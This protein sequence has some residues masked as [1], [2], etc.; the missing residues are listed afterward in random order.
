ML[1]RSILSPVTKTHVERR[2]L[3]THPVHLF[4]IIENV[5]DYAFFLPLCSYSKIL[6]RHD[7]TSF[8]ARLTVGL[9]PFFEETYVSR[10]KTDPT[11][12]IIKSDSIQSKLFDS[13]SS[14]WHLT[15]TAGN[16]CMVDFQVNMTVS[17]PVIV[18]V[19]DQV[20]QQVAAKQVDAF[21]Q[22]C[23]DLPLPKDITGIDE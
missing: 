18:S 13:L 22:R 19:L 6:S 8:D 15:K 2:I 3:K 12:L 17:D 23:R 21:D 14:R 10:V 5:D 16:D 20:L 7:G 11:N 4:R 1:F 9:P